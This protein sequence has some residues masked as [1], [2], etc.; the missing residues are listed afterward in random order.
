M[1]GPVN[2]DIQPPPIKPPEAPKGPPVPAAISSPEATIPPQPSLDLDKIVA[3]EVEE[4]VLAEIKLKGLP[5]VNEAELRARLEKEARDKYAKPEENENTP[6][7]VKPPTTSET[8]D[9]PP[10][11]SSSPTNN[12][13]KESA[14]PEKTLAEKEAEFKKHWGKGN[15]SA[16]GHLVT[17]DW[18]TVTAPEDKKAAINA[19][20]SQYKTLI[21]AINDGNIRL[22]E[23]TGTYYIKNPQTGEETPFIQ[24]GEMVDTVLTA[25][26]I[27]AADTSNQPRAAEA[28]ANAKVL[29]ENLTSGGFFKAQTNEEQTREKEIERNKEA[30]DTIATLV[31]DTLE[32]FAEQNASEPNED[33]ATL[34]LLAATYQDIPDNP[35][36]PRRQGQRDNLMTLAYE[37]LKK[38]KLDNIT[39]SGL[40]ARLETLQKGIAIFEGGKGRLQ[41]LENEINTHWLAPQRLGEIP[42]ERL[43]RDMILAIRLDATSGVKEVHDARGQ[44][45]R[46]EVGDDVED[47]FKSWDVKEDERQQIFRLA[48]GD[49]SAGRLMSQEFGFDTQVLTDNKSGEKVAQKILSALKNSAEKRSQQVKY[50]TQEKL[51]AFLKFFKNNL[52]EESLKEFAKKHGLPPQAGMS[53][54]ILALFLPMIQGVLDT[55][56]GGGGEERG[57]GGG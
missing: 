19:V 7:T 29:R 23:K 3:Q 2:V 44:F 14:I 1:P 47:L 9:K 35:N 27:L 50:D 13:P 12:V 42:L 16:I 31:H 53:V 45:L 28:S 18:D 24:T 4:G 32:G 33:V 40:R 37:A 21:Q 48:T 52:S 36:D 54:L 6:K 38:I 10:A 17:T 15:D 55:G 8:K 43:T 41:T 25:E 46:Y 39:G 56:G 34:S 22:D 30:T 26:D 51:D 49:H 20:V 11:Q 57:G 5:N